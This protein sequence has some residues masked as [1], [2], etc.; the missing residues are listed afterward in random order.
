V[1]SD[2]AKV[3]AEVQLPNGKSKKVK[4][5]DLEVIFPGPVRSWEV[6]ELVSEDSVNFVPPD[7]AEEAYMWV[8][9]EPDSVTL[10]DLACI[11]WGDTTFKTAW[12][13]WKLVQEDTFFHGS[14]EAIQ[15][16]PRER[17]DAQVAAKEAR[18]KEEADRQA[19]AKR[20]KN[21]KPTKADRVVLKDVENIAL[22]KSETSSVLKDLGMAQTPDVA[23]KLLLDLGVW[24]ENDNPWAARCG[25]PE[26]P[27][28]GGKQALPQEE[29]EDLTHLTAF[30]ID[31]QGSA[32]PDDAITCLEDGTCWVHVADVSALAG[33]GSDV[34]VEA[35]QRVTTVYLPQGPMPMLPDAV[36]EELGMGLREVS[37]ALSFS[38]RLSDEGELEDIKVCKSL[39]KVTRLSYE[40][41]ARRLDEGDEELGRM[42]AVAD[43]FRDVRMESGAL[44][45]N[46][47]DAKVSVDAEGEVTITSI[48]D[49]RSMDMVTEFMLMAGAAASNFA[50]EQ[51]I[52][53]LFSSQD[54]PADPVPPQQKK[55]NK[56][57][58]KPPK[59][60]PPP[61]PVKAPSTLSEMF[62]LRRRLSRSMIKCTP[63]FHSSLGMPLYSQVTS[64]L[65]RYGDLLLHQQ[66]RS[67][68]DGNPLREAQELEEQ[69]KVVEERIG[70]LKKAERMSK[71]WYTLVWLLRNP[72]WQGDAVCV[73]FWQARPSSPRIAQVLIPELG[74][75]ANVKMREDVKK[76][77]YMTVKLRGVRLIDLR[78]DW[79]HIAEE[80]MLY[81]TEEAEEHANLKA[82]RSRKNVGTRMFTT[83]KRQG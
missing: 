21:L 19:F 36:T 51:G 27:P 69:V 13:T 32:D 78:A 37:P 20:I 62:E 46:F 5:T 35:R 59:K 23:L 40:E 30:A 38:F 25:V 49:L 53:F 67:F 52:P 66:L 58:Q 77:E 43:R 3:K 81:G 55:G 29:R 11:I 76:D 1:V 48:P 50:E 72:N 63:G 74:L 6:A 61:Q 41:A 47:P 8:Q 83:T 73:G 9:D 34:D 68:L 26:E 17:V 60:A 33:P 7:A 10:D 12:A 65:R 28:T 2:I 14:P 45:F 39:V 15:A 4:L 16:H 44:G 24:T 64:P 31:D 22:M 80:K 57:V 71:Q 79:T 18:E 42:E 70:G 75:F 82:F 54:P 56:A